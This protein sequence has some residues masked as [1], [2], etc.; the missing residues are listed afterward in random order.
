MPDEHTAVP[1]ELTTGD[2]D[3]GHL[4]IRLFGKDLDLVILSV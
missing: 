4:T 1:E 3:L 2:E